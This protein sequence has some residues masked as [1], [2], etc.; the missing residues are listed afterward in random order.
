MYKI[1]DAEQI[2]RCDAYTIQH[3]P[4]DPMALMERASKA[5]FGR[6]VDIFPEKG[7]AFHVLCGPG[8]N[9]GDGAAIARML[10]VAGYEVVGYHPS[11]EA[12]Q[13][14][15]LK[16]N[17][18]RL[19]KSGVPCKAL[20]DVVRMVVMPN[21]V[22]ID[23]LFG[24]GLKRPLE[25]IY[26]EVA[27]FLTKT[28]LDVISIDLPSGMPC[29]GLA[30]HEPGACVKSS[31][32]LSLQ[33]PKFCFLLSENESYA[34]SWE[35][36][37]IGLH[38]EIILAEPTNYFIIDE[39]D[40]TELLMP[41][42]PFTHKGQLG[43]ALLLGGSYGKAGAVQLMADACLRSGTGLVSAGLPSSCLVPVHASAP[44]CM[45]IPDPCNSHLSHLPDIEPFTAI[46]FGP[47]V[48]T[49]PETAKVLKLLIQQARQ[50]LVIDADGLN[51][52]AQ[53]P[54]WLAFLPAETILTPHVGEF[55]R[56]AGKITNSIDRLEKARELSRKWN[57]VV[58]LKGA[59]TAIISPQGK[60]FFNPSGN[61]GM[62]TGGSGDVLTGIISGLRAQGYQALHAAIIGVYV[63]GLA[64]DLAAEQLGMKALKAGDIVNWLP[65]AWQRLGC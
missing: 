10:H 9:G 54:T 49:G 40:V 64:G 37:D 32:V 44:E 19:Q 39:E 1:F 28:G 57:A 51:I 13:S 43:H 55:H 33:F 17:I 63:H 3:E 24:S 59:F 2:R 52:L 15:G 35:V 47:G 41:L 5:C 42:S 56:L 65:E 23:A 34:P 50:G 38:T 7:T 12:W 11:P 21:M 22:I 20:G 25:G 58:V 4:V 31:H 8:N 29:S 27:A 53:N 48:G 61:P 46:G 62:A 18:E 6:L 16:V 36:V 14:E 26:R 45:C 60:V 30:D